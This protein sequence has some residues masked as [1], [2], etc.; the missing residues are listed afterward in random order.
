VTATDQFPVTASV[1]MPEPAGKAS[2]Q[3]RGKRSN[4]PAPTLPEWTAAKVV[5]SIKRMEAPELELVLS[6]VRNV[7][8][9]DVPARVLVKIS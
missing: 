1:S 6:T 3:V 9:K 8:T 5:R 2:S 4:E 7:T